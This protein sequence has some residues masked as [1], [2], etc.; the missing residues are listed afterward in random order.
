MLHLK[1][2]IVVLK[3]IA[4]VFWWCGIAVLA[5]TA[6]Q[7]AVD[8]QKVVGCDDVKRDFADLNAE[9]DKRFAAATRNSSPTEDRVARVL[10][11]SANIDVPGLKEAREKSEACDLALGRKWSSLYGVILAIPLFAICFV[12]GG[13]FWRPPKLT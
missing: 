1:A 4:V 13:T 12:L 6:W 5:I 8:L 10:R 11:G 2:G 3:R 7:T 9:W